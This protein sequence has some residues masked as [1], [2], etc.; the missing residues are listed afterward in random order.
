MNVA[1]PLTQQSAAYA[2]RVRL[3]FFGMPESSQKR[4]ARSIR[5]ANRS[6]RKQAAADWQREFYMP[7]EL[8]RS[9]RWGPSKH[10]M[11][12]SLEF[13]YSPGHKQRGRRSEKPWHTKYFHEIQER[14]PRDSRR[15]CQH[16]RKPC[17]NPT[18]DQRLKK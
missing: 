1:F 16:W 8:P 10:C 9:F 17:V 7:V 4:H 2:K 12:R 15:G 11:E 3:L 5:S 14:R 13:R 6:F 18:L